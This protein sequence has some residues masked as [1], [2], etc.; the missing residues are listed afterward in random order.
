MTHNT[1]QPQPNEGERQTP[2]D[3]EAI[4]AQFPILDQKIHG[5]PFVYLDSGATAYDSIEK[6]KEL[7]IYFE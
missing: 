1:Q 6:I 3:F 2:V 7:D 5:H 4:R